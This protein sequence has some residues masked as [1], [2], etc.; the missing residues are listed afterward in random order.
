MQEW[1]GVHEDVTRRIRSVAALVLFI[2]PAAI[3]FFLLFCL[4]Y[5]FVQVRRASNRA[6]MVS[7]L[8]SLFQ[9]SYN[10]LRLHNEVDLYN[11]F[12]ASPSRL[13]LMF[14]LFIVYSLLH[15]LVFYLH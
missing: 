7:R 3:L 10:F 4:A 9:A 5:V 13:C 14:Q 12:I 15:Y 1:D 11:N 2:L 8:I 6:N